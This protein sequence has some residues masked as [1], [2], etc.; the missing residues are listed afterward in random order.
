MSSHVNAAK[1]Q[2]RQLMLTAE[3]QAACLLGAEGLKVALVDAAAAR[4]IAAQDSDSVMP[5]S[6][7]QDMIESCREAARVLHMVA[8]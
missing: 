5:L 4:W 2:M 7:T 8:S 1:F 3:W 6:K